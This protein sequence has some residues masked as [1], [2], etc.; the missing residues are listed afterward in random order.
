MK[1]TYIV[2][3]VLSIILVFATLYLPKTF[4][5]QNDFN[6]VRCGFPF[7]FFVYSSAVSP[8]LPWSADCLY[9][10]PQ[11][12]PKQFIWSSFFI[13]VGIVY[14]VLWLFWK[15]VKINKPRIHVKG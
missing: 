1:K 4:Y 10:T 12:A 6:N 5:N 14:A 9:G 3:F 7:E 11:G 13:D 8:P 15:I 2:I